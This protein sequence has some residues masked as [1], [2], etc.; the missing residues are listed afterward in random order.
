MKELVMP[1]LGSHFIGNWYILTCQV[2]DNHGYAC[3]TPWQANTSFVSLEEDDI[4]KNYWTILRI[5]N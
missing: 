5:I 2:I 3:P 1:L 4:V